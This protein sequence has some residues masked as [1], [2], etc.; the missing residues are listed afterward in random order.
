MKHVSFKVRWYMTVFNVV[1]H[2]RIWV[3]GL[4]RGDISAADSVFATDCTVHITGVAQ[5]I[6]GAA[7]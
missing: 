4:N 7:A 3:E 6:R 2:E 5:P 1:E